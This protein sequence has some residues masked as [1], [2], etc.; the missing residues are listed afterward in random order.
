MEISQSELAVFCLATVVAGVIL[1]FVYDACAW[2]P[3]IGGKTFCFS[4]RER[5]SEIELP[6]LKRKISAGKSNI[7]DFTEGFFVFLHDLIFM[8]FAGVALAF[9]LY[10]FNYGIWRFYC[11]IFALIGFWVY[12]KIFRFPVVAL[13]EIVRFLI[14]AIA[15]YVVYFI[16]KP[17]RA[18]AL[19]S[20]KHFAKKALEIRKSKL[21]KYIIKYSEKEVKKIKASATVSGCLDFKTKTGERNVRRKQK[22]DFV[23]DDLFTCRINN[24]CEH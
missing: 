16:F 19:R 10:R 18:F 3:M 7:K 9:I 12:R 1:G 8:I 24:S 14:K 22:K 4:V 20:K 13:V 21:N 11:L 5:L 6:L 23:D 2:L 17:I 15:L